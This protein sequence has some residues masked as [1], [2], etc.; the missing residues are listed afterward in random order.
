[1][2]LCAVCGKSGAGGIKAEQGGIGIFPLGGV[3]TSCFAESSAIGGRIQDVIG[4]LVGN[5]EGG[6]QRVKGW[7][8]FVVAGGRDGTAVQRGAN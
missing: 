8:V 2:C 4:D 3:F 5:P 1:M 6:A 7:A